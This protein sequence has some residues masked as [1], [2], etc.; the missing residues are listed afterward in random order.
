MRGDG[1][2]YKPKRSR[3]LYIAYCH[4]GKEIC[5]SAREA[6]CA[7]AAR[8]RNFTDQDARGV[9]ERLLKKR[10]REIDNDKEGL[11]PF[12]GPQQDRLTVGNLLDSLESE[13]KLRNIK[14]LHQTQNHLRIVRKYFGDLRAVNVSTDTIHRYIEKSL[15]DGL[16]P[17]TVN[18]RTALLREAFRLAMRR[19]RLSFVPEF[20]RLRVD[21]AREGFFS[22]PEFFAVLSNLGDQDIADYMEWF[23]WTGM[24]P[25][26]IRS[27]TWQAFDRETWTLRLHAR[28]AKTGK[29]R[30]LALEGPL[31]EIIQRRMRARRFSCDLI[32]HRNGKSVGTFYKRWYRA[33]KAAE[34]SERRRPYDCRRTAVRNMLRAGVSE[35]IAMSISG[36]RTRAVFDRYNIVNEQ[37][38]AEALSKTTAYVRSLPETKSVVAI[39][40]KAVSESGQ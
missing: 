9:A 31:Q 3:Y 6:I 28:N 10:L 34:I 39:D 36:H 4:N 27:L 35:R 1:R 19:R 25:G 38:I 14:S 26:E 5:E 29:G 12:V 7:A 30:V 11:K 20:P 15:T 24:R 18:G 8:K 13:L 2:I 16:A 22:K 23:Y 32:F 33:C 40:Q 17:S 21:N 37:D